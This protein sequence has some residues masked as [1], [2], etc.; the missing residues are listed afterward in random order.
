V[1]CAADLGKEL[2]RDGNRRDKREL[3]RRLKVNESF[4]DGG[5]RGLKLKDYHRKGS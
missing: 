4:N 1:K 5:E 2:Q 3:E